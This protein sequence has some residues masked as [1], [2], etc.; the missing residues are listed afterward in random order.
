MTLT[1][2]GMKGQQL[3]IKVPK[4]HI[5]RTMSRFTDDL[6]KNEDSK[7]PVHTAA[8][9]GSLVLSMDCLM[10]CFRRIFSKVLQC[11]QLPF[12]K[13]D[14]LATILKLTMPSCSEDSQSNPKCVAYIIKNN[15]CQWTMTEDHYT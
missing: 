6:K 3:E 12:H 9:A 13:I 4:V 5:W 11:L 7:S 2:V 15:T 8:R 1:H 14:N 10:S